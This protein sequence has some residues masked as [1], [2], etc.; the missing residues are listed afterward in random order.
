MLNKTIYFSLTEKIL[1]KIFFFFITILSLK[2]SNEFYSNLIIFFVLAGYFYEIVSLSIPKIFNSFYKS[3]GL[4]RLSILAGVNFYLSMLILIFFFLLIFFN[5]N[6]LTKSYQIKDLDIYYAIIILGFSIFLNEL[7]NQYV[8][9]KL[10]HLYVYLYDIFSIII[11][12]SISFYIFENF[13]FL[14]IDRIYL[15]IFLYACIQIFLK[16][17]KFLIFKSDI[18]LNINKITFNFDISEFINVLK[19]IIPILTVSI[20]ILTQLNIARFVIISFEGFSNFAIFVF[21]VQVIELCGIFFAAIHQLSDPKISILISNQKFFK[22]KLLKNQLFNI[23]LSTV[24]IIFAFIF[25]LI[26]DL[27]LILGVD[28]KIKLNLFVFL[29]INYLLL[30]LF[31]TIYQY[32]IMI[33]QRKFLI[34]VVFIT[35][36]FNLVFSL[37][38]MKFFSIFGVAVANLISN[39]F[40]FLICNRYTNFFYIRKK[41]LYKILFLFLKFFFIVFFLNLFNYFIISEEIYFILIAKILYIILLFFIVESISYKNSSLNYLNIFIKFI[42]KKS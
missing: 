33:N 20:L 42:L 2:I 22:L 14:L 37:I 16:F 7:I 5:Q 36:F 3:F 41:N 29:S 32:I 31:F 38:L 4:K 27:V 15:I 1:N 17:I 28:I 21:H 25:F 23:F 11:L 12:F 19:L 18:I 9:I 24:P 34:K 30:Y 8:F 10:K 39:L 35:L 26:N 40:L 6:F 13:K